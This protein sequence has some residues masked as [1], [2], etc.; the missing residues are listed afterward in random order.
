MTFLIAMLTLLII[1]IPFIIFIV[2][3]YQKYWPAK[4]GFN[5][6]MIL[7]I[8][9]IYSLLAASLLFITLHSEN[10]YINAALMGATIYGVYSFTVY[11]LVP[12]WPIWLAGLETAWGAIMMLIATAV[13][14]FLTR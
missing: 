12:D 7:G 6:K 14:K 5:L 1:D 4:V 11:S 2:Q 3:Q 8:F 13:L 9:V 10:P